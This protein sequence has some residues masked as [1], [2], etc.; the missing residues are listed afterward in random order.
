MTVSTPLRSAVGLAA[1]VLL[2][3]LGGA[4][5]QEAGPS[6]VRTHLVTG[7]LAR[8][9]LGRRVLVVKVKPPEGA[10]YELEVQTDEGTRIS[11]R[12]RALAL[13]EMRPGERVLVSCSDEGPRHRALLVKMGAPR[14]SPLLQPKAAVSPAGS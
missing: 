1:L 3:G 4:S 11:S 12:G 14:K 2:P 13:S 7:E 10:A 8:L 6:R 9:D 5:A